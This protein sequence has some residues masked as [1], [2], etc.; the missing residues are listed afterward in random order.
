MEGPPQQ[1]FELNYYSPL[2]GLRIH[3]N[4]WTVMGLAVIALA[5]FFFLLC[6]FMNVWFRHCDVV[7]N[8]HRLA[9]ENGGNQGR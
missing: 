1:A 3:L 9:F 2:F 5:A 6:F 4:S 7:S 8:H